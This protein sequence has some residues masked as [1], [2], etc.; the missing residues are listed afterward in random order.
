MKSALHYAAI[1]LLFGSCANIVPPSGGD[2][3]TIPPLVVAESPPNES[4]RFEAGKIEIKFDEY[5]QLNDAFNQV[6][7]SPPLNAFPDIRVKGKSIIIS[8][9]DTLLEETTYTIQ[10]GDC[11]G[12]ITENNRLSNYVYA[13]S[14]G[15]ELD[16][17]IIRG[18]IRDAFSGSMPEKALAV[19]YRNTA[20]SAFLNQ[21]PTYFA[22][23]DANG[24]FEINHIKE[25]TY[26]LYGLTDQ[27]FNYY[28]DLPNESIA[29]MED[30]LIVQNDTSGLVLSLF[31]EESN[32]LFISDFRS[33]GPGKLRLVWSAPTDTFSIQSADTIS[34]L[35]II[36]NSLKDSLTI[37]PGQP[38]TE[39]I[40]LRVQSRN[41]DTL[42]TAAIPPLDSN[43]LAASNKWTNAP[44][45]G[46]ENSRSR[47]PAQELDNPARL[48][49]D[50]P[51]TAIDPDSIIL[52]ID[53]GNHVQPF[54]ATIDSA[55]SRRL[56]ITATWLTDT[57]YTLELKGGATADL[58]GRSNDSLGYTFR[59]RSQEE[60]G[61]LFIELLA[62][63]RQTFIAE[64]IKKD[65]SVHAR[66]VIPPFLDSTRVVWKNLLPETYRLRIIDDANS[67]GKW[68]TGS[69]PAKR[70]PERTFYYD[71]ELTIR[72]NWEYTT[73]FR[74]K[75]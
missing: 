66:Q 74:I 4:L 20:D 72:P 54:V 7:I 64:L 61:Q 67:N 50:V 43:F 65:G 41:I 8:L 18:N 30:S 37:W 75:Y 35:L 19:L 2:K 59:T 17:L 22:K 47:L 21:K 68:D 6:V 26:R 5:V 14:T 10:F 11:I 53:S 32:Q 48:I 24:N 58:Y 23:C 52:T 69:L 38:L 31:E 45:S 42:L 16:S 27:N 28:Y 70:Q 36:S 33:A 73:K 46:G 60:Y 13:F 51:L 3:D 40:Q 29:F 55:D 15:D 63:G 49:F 44:P 34:S 57:V 1:T 71:A 9:E 56:L 25:G 39:S 62:E 12:D